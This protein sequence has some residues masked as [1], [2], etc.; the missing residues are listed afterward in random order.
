M[1][2]KNTIFLRANTKYEKNGI[3]TENTIEN[4]VGCCLVKQIQLLKMSVVF[5]TNSKI[6]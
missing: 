5:K 4:N 1:P 6:K 2:N 3:N